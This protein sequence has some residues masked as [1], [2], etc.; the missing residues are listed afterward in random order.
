MRDISYDDSRYI[1]HRT[2]AVQPQKLIPAN[3]PLF[4]CICAGEPRARAFL[5]QF[6]CIVV[7]L[8]TVQWSKPS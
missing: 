2:F 7:L 1:R 3:P 4:I 6:V 5:T 8:R